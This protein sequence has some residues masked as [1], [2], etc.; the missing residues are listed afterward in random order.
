MSTN[1]STSIDS[2][3]TLV[4]GVDY[5][6]AEYPNDRGDAIVALETK[7]GVDG[8]TITTSHDYKIDVLETFMNSGVK[9]GTSTRS[10]E[11]AQEITGIGYK[12]S[13]VLFL[14]CDYTATNI[15]ISVGFDDGTNH[16]YL[17]HGQ[18]G[19]YQ[20]IDTTA[21]IYVIR[22]GGNLIAGEITA[23]GADGFTITWTLIGTCSCRFAYLTLP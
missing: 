2:F 16:A 3:A 23:T 21:S 15:N 1:F 22:D 19:V 8:S 20:G 18:S 7:V 11:G 14:A 13:V 12:P 17:Y 5:P 4:D 6:K 9:I 10:T